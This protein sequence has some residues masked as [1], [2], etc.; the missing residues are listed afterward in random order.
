MTSTRAAIGLAVGLLLTTGGVVEIA[1]YFQGYVLPNGTYQPW[2][3]P[4]G[5]GWALGIVVFIGGFLLSLVSAYSLGKSAV[6]EALARPKTVPEN[7]R[8]N[9]R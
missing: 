3:D 8:D 7:P 6:Q 5:L 2:V 9:H 1:S 4:S